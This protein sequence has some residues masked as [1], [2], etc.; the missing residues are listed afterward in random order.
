MQFINYY[1]EGNYVAAFYFGKIGALYGEC[2]TNLTKEVAE[3]TTTFEFRNLTSSSTKD[4]TALN[5]S[6]QISL[7]LEKR[8]VD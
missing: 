2:I 3:E 8:A 1:F 7:E 5:V 6:A 4:C